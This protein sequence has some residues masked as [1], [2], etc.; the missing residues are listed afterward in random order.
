MPAAG[1]AGRRSGVS[2]GGMDTT[3]AVTLLQRC[4]DRMRALYGDVVFDEWAAVTLGSGG[5]MLRHYEGPRLETFRKRFTTDVKPLQ[6]ELEGRKL[7]VGEF[8][9]VPDAPGT[10]YDVCVHAGPRIY[11]LGNHTQRTMTEIRKDPRWLDAQRAFVEM[12]EAFAADPWL[13]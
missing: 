2:D 13:V 5:D 1:Q 11:V 10:A 4:R 6:A 3:T 9:F 8:S 7:A 12:T